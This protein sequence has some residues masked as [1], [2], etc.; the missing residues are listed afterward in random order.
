MERGAW[1]ATVHGVSQLDTTLQLTLSLFKHF[2]TLKQVKYI[3]EA[4]SLT[5]RRS[6]LDCSS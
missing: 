2:E 6:V 1:E 5:S 3:W 4:P